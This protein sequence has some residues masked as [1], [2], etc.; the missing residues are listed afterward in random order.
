MQVSVLHA[1]KSYGVYVHLRDLILFILF[2]VLS[3]YTN[4][5]FL[6]LNATATP[7]FVPTAS[8]AN[9]DINA[10]PISAYD[11]KSTRPAITLVLLELIIVLFFAIRW[12]CTRCV[13]IYY[14]AKRKDPHL[15]RYLGISDFSI[16]RELA[17]LA[18]FSLTIYGDFVRLRHRAETDRSSYTIAVA[19]MLQYLL[20]I[21]YF[22]PFSVFGPLIGMIEAILWDIKWY[23][24][25]LTIVVYGFSQ[26]IFL[27][28]WSEPGLAAFDGPG[29]ALAQSLVYLVGNPTFPPPGTSGTSARVAEFLSILLTV[30]GSIILLNLLIAIMNSSYTRIYER[31]EAEWVKQICITITEQTPITPLQVRTEG[32]K[33]IH[34]LRRKVDIDKETEG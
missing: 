34:Y 16:W 14:T 32:D 24:L 6:L 12:I 33:F 4:Y 15:F 26:A 9:D 22:R 30:I 7:S 18:W 5:T 28:S 13:K 17:W 21:L 8:P 23:I 3:S 1:W 29:D 11:S 27:A 25:I 2:L 31:S 19:T 10:H 20:V